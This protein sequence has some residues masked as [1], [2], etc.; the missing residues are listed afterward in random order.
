MIK[1]TVNNPRLSASAIQI[2][3]ARKTDVNISIIKILE[4][5]KEADYYYSPPKA[6]PRLTDLNI[7][8]PNI[9]LL[10]DFEKQKFG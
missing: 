4:I 9:I 2:I 3:I 1:E 5:R 7:K 10:F 8:K 6:M